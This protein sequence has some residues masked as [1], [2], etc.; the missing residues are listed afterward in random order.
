MSFVSDLTFGKANEEIVLA[1]VQEL[2]PLDE[3]SLSEIKTYVDIV[4]KGW[5][6]VEC[7]SDR[8]TLT[9]W[10]VFIEVSCSWKPSW[11]FK[12]DSLDVLAYSYWDTTIFTNVSKLK[13]FLH[14]ND[15]RLRKIKAGDGWRSLGYLVNLEDY[16]SLASIII[17]HT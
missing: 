6:T 11:I 8:Q 2:F 13:S 14:N 9:T 7:K 4:S 12:Y 3:W 16:K 15:G 5:L 17:T 10:N 1:M